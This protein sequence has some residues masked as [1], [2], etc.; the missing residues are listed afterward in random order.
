T[1][2]FNEGRVI[3]VTNRKT[4]KPITNAK[5]EI[6][7]N[8][9]TIESGS[10]DK[11]GV[12]SYKTTD[13]EGNNAVVFA[14]N[15][16]DFA[17]SDTYF[18]RG[19]FSPTGACYIYTS[20]PVYRPE[21][22][23]SFKAIVR[24]LKNEEYRLPKTGS[25][26]QIKV[27]DAKN[28]EIYNKYLKVN[29]FGSVYGEVNLKDTSS[30]GSYTIIASYNNSTYRYYFKVEKYKK[31]EYEVK[32]TTE[33]KN[34]IKGDTIKAKIQAKYYFGSP[35]S[36]GK[37][38]Y[39]VYRTRYFVPWWDSSYGWYYSSSE[40]GEDYSYS[41]TQEV[42]SGSELD[43]KPDGTIEIE[44]DTKKIDTEYADRYSG[45][46]DKESD[47]SYT[48]SATVVDQ[49]RSN[50]SGSNK[51][52]VTRS[53][54]HL[55][56]ST[57]KWLYEPNKPIDIEVTAKRFDGNFANDQEITLEFYEEK[58]EQVNGRYKYNERFISKKTGVTNNK[59]NF[60]TT[61]LASKP[62]WLIV[63]AVSKD[64]S[65]NKTDYKHYI[66]VYGVDSYADRSSKGGIT[67]IADKSS[68]KV[69]D[70]AKIV[71]NTPVKRGWL[72]VTCEASS[73]PFFKVLPI[74]KGKVDID[75]KMQD[76]FTPNIWVNGTI[77]FNNKLYTARKEIIIP[78]LHKFINVEVIS[79]KEQYKPGEPAKFTIKTTDYN[80]KPIKSE[81]SVGI[82]DASIYA[83]APES[84]VDVRKYFYSKKYN[85]VSTSSALYFRFSG[86]FTDKMLM[87]KINSNPSTSFASFKEDE[88]KN[89]KQPKIRK[90]FKDEIL[91]LPTVLTSSSGTATL[92]FKFP[93]NLTRWHTTVRAVTK[94]TYVGNVVH[95][96]I[97]R[98]NLLVRL[99]LP[100][101][102]REMDKAI[103]STIVHN[104]LNSSK[105]TVISLEGKGIELLT[106]GKK[107]VTI[108]KNGEIRIDWEVKAVNAGT[109]TLLAKALTD[110]ESD[111][112]QKTLPILPHGLPT[113]DPVVQELR[114]N[115]EKF[116]QSIV[117]KDNF[118]PNFTELKIDLAPTVVVAMNAAL[119]YLVK[120]PY[121]CVEQTMSRFLPLVLV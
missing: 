85:A 42:K 117:F 74:N 55:R 62:M 54:H 49:S 91:W 100:R 116:T 89:L 16:A 84:A 108:P 106:K 109:A 115:N 112:V 37:V 70:N 110:E 1:K 43:L 64:K 17:L 90:D 111:A 57:S 113:I 72:L 79:D 47:Y 60:N 86:E 107:R 30:L 98:K 24:E 120:E 59:G 56:I 32:V 48:I 33:K 63:R 8:K 93:D 10:T 94:K 7:S 83:I 5:I 20:R 36:K 29:D 61:F 22:K 4:G 80:G 11:N 78:P 68:Y 13:K 67:I 2:T 114:K 71:F 46:R 87:S 31:P 82:V 18:Y 104:Y 51:V 95:K 3:F 73:I 53:D 44:I 97:V 45:Y 76:S 19:Y 69:G 121:G 26:V 96:T 75:I 25:E 14:Q 99:A 6:Y 105:K 28:T 88:D 77:V 35:V 50:I 21:Q 66:Y 103:V 41:R 23:V 27:K 52:L 58:W 102:Y 9:K 12:Y 38:E 92:S 40:D 81:V 15:G 34:Y 119:P 101:F 118:I 65:G 39:H